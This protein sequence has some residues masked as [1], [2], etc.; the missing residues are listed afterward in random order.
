[1]VEVKSESNSS[2]LHFSE[3]NSCKTKVPEKL[4]TNNNQRN[5]FAL[6]AAVDKS[7]KQQTLERKC[8]MSVKSPESVK[9]DY[10]IPDAKP[11]HDYEDIDQFSSTSSSQEIKLSTK[12]RKQLSSFSPLREPVSMPSPL[13]SCARDEER[14]YDY[15]NEWGSSAS[16]EETQKLSTESSFSSEI[17]QPSFNFKN[18]TYFSS[19]ISS[20]SLF[21]NSSSSV[22]TL[23]RQ[24]SSLSTK[25]RV[26]PNGDKVFTLNKKGLKLVANESGIKDHPFLFGL[27]SREEY[28]MKNNLEH[29]MKP[30]DK[31]LDTSPIKNRSN[32]ADESRTRC[33]TPRINSSSV[34]RQINE[35]FQ[36]VKK[37]VTKK[38]RK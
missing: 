21:N 37:V 15:P 36:R 17:E 32:F 31:K 20:G 8:S 13:E 2:P 35:S 38:L 11:N 7:R 30:S 34:G 29:V 9:S 28:A 1:M 26:S 25:D 33:G 19:P 24:Q 22:G 27:M 4:S 23:A 18:P 12:H 6:Y 16:S 5:L 10:G 14:I 3:P